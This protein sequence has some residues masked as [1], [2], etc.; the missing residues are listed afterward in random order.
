LPLS[1]GVRGRPRDTAPPPSSLCPSGGTVKLL[2][3]AKR[4][5]DRLSAFVSPCFVPTSNTLA[6]ISGATNAVQIGSANLGS[7]VLVGQGAGRLPTANSCVS[8]ILDIAQ[9][10]SAAPFPKQPLTPALKFGNSYTSSFYVRIRF[11]EQ[12]GIIQSVGEIFSDAGVS[13]YNLL[14]TP[15]K[16]PN[17]SMFVI[18]TDPVDVAKIKRAC[19][20]LEATD[21]CLGDTFYMPVVE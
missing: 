2:G 10:T 4:D 13:I 17:D 20:A 15:I 12:L 9:G 1:G 7:T 19:V 14:Q 6:S 8:D 5:G 21:W 3:V 18:T 16:N 11:R